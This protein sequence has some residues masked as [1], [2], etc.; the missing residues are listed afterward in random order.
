MPSIGVFGSADVTYGLMVVVEGA[1]NGR[2]P[3]SR[4]TGFFQWSRGGIEPLTATPEPQSGQ[5]H[6]AKDP[7]PLAH[8]LA[9]E[10]KKAA[11]VGPAGALDPAAF[12]G[13]LARLPEAGRR[14]GLD[15]LADA[16]RGLPL[17]ER[18][19]L[20]AKLLAPP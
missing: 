5:G 8:T 17:A 11:P 18:A 16:L 6:A 13:V 12:V 20:A 19:A 4:T 3:S 9:R 7:V 2:T 1:G 15:A 14:A 10:P